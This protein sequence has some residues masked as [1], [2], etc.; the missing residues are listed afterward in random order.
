MVGFK[1]FSQGS[2]PEKCREQLI[3]YMRIA[4]KHEFK[5]DKFDEWAKKREICDCKSNGAYSYMKALE[6]SEFTIIK[7]TGDDLEV[8]LLDPSISPFNFTNKKLDW[9]EITA[10]IRGD[11]YPIPG[12]RQT[13]IDPY[14]RIPNF[15]LPGDG[16]EFIDLNLKVEIRAENS[17]KKTEVIDDTN[18]ENNPKNTEII[19]SSDLNQYLSSFNQNFNCDTLKFYGKTISFNDIQTISDKYCYKGT[20]FNGCIFWSYENGQIQSQKQ[21]KDGEVNGKV[22]TYFYDNNYSKEDYID[23]TK[24]SGLKIQLEELLIGFN[25]ILKDSISNNKLLRDYII[26]SIQGYEKLYK[27]KS[28]YIKNRLKGKKLELFRKYIELNQN[29]ERCNQNIL[30]VRKEFGVIK[31]QISNEENKPVY[32]PK[33]EIIYSQNNQ[34]KN[35]IY[36]TFYP[37]QKLKEKGQYVKD[38]QNG[39]WQFYF[40]NGIIKGIGQFKNGNGQEIGISGIPKN[41]R[42]GFWKTYYDNGNLF[43]EQNI[44][45]D[46]KVYIKTY[47]K[48]GKIQQIGEY[49]KFEKDLKPLGL[50]VLYNE[51]GDKIKEVDYL[52]DNRSKVEKNYFKNGQIFSVINYFDS[53]YH[54]KV[55]LYREDGKIEKES[56]YKFGKLNGLVKSYFPNGNVHF[57][58]NF[59]NNQLQGVLAEYYESGKI[60]LKGNTDTTAA[61]LEN[62]ELRLFGDAI[63]YNEDGTINAHYFVNKDGTN[64]DKLKEEKK[65]QNSKKKFKY[66]NNSKS[67]CKWCKKSVYCE[68]REQWEL[69]YWKNMDPVAEV[70]FDVFNKALSL[71]Q[72]YE[73]QIDLYNCPNFC[74]PKCEYESKEAGN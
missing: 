53:I 59:C 47:F 56:T 10:L 39:T 41:G 27:L 32:F 11:D 20:I 5:R 44:R 60:K 31:N 12:G 28:R 16:C 40:E 64:T 46:K 35:G 55:I 15:G 34:L 66:I 19:N 62:S 26:N 65:L 48:N 38:L 45:D 3:N 29:S 67:T 21:I 6:N 69:D 8:N 61:L 36:L 73:P 50:H 4:L 42:I 23:S 17:L 2:N 1:S 51:N 7:G 43:Q 54:G 49:D 25:A 57:E 52:S 18:K 37:N 70:F 71:E 63:Y 13:Q 9:K 72:E 24:L 58:S 22:V 74:S 33:I 68:K 30:T 14:L